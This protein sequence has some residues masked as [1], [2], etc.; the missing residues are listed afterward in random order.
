VRETQSKFAER[1]LVEWELTR[2]K[3]WQV[4]PKEMLGKLAH[5]VTRAEAEEKRA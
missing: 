3:I 1:L 2:T 4:V 5:P